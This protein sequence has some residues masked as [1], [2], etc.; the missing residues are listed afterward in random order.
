MGLKLST[1]ELMSDI[2]HIVTNRFNRYTTT[3]W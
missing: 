2:L 1:F 3:Y